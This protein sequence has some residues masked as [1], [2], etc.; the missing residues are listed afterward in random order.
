MKSRWR[1][2]EWGLLIACLLPLI[3]WLPSAAG[4]GIA[5]GADVEVHV[6]RIHAMTLALQHGDLWPRWISYLHLGY[7]YPIFNYYAPGATYLTSLFELGGLHIT[8]AWNLVNLLAWSAGSA[9][10]YLLTRRFLPVPAALLSAALWVFAPSRLYE[11]W[12]QGSIAQMVSAA[13][14]P[15][16]LWGILKNTVHP[17]RRRVLLVA[18]PFAGLILT[19]TPMTYISAL[20]AAPLA[21]VAPLW[22]V[23][24]KDFQWCDVLSRWLAIG[25]GFVLGVGL[26]AIFLMPTL[27]ELGYV[28]ISAGIDETLV[29]LQEQY[30]PAAEIFAWPRL[31]DRTDIYLDFPRTLGLVGGLLSAAG[32]AGTLESTETR[33]VAASADWPRIHCLYAAVG[34]VSGLAGD[35][36]I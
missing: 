16:L 4:E 22:H 17:T 1:Q 6:H 2:I 14:I 15:W 7:G 28:I 9:G 30:L 5:A 12:W 32:A 18:L 36:V 8:T 35:S 26:A 13:C 25:S 24:K 20:Y 23:W 21:F 33:S 29:Y 31:L 34:V 19:H 3:A 11:I 10:M 27:L